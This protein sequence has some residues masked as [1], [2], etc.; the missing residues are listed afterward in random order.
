MKLN[1]NQKKLFRFIDDA[2]IDGIKK[3]AHKIIKKDFVNDDGISPFMA[4]MKQYDL[5]VCITLKNELFPVEA[6]PGSGSAILQALL[7]S[8]LRQ[9]DIAIKCGADVNKTLQLGSN[10]FPLGLAINYGNVSFA[11]KLIELGSE[12][13][14]YCKID[15]AEMSD[16]FP[17]ILLAAQTH[18][19]EMFDLIM[20]SAEK[21]STK[22]GLSIFYILMCTQERRDTD[23]FKNKVLKILLDKDIPF[24]NTS[25]HESID[26]IPMSTMFTQN[27]EPK[28]IRLREKIILRLIED[29]NINTN[30]EDL[31]QNNLLKLSV[32]MGSE[33][34]TK[35]FIKKGLSPYKQ[36]DQGYTAFHNAA[37]LKDKNTASA[38]MELLT[39]IKVDEISPL[40]QSKNVKDSHY[41]LENEDGRTA[42]DLAFMF[43]NYYAAKLL[44]QKGA[45]ITLSAWDRDEEDVPLWAQLMCHIQCQTDVENIIFFIKQGMDISSYES[46]EF[47]FT[48]SIS[49][50][51]RARMLLQNEFKIHRKFNM[52]RGYFDNNNAY[53]IIDLKPLHS[54]LKASE[55]DNSV[56]GKLSLNANMLEDIL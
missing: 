14:T 39:S 44:I 7:D 49:S 29:K 24:K 12:T 38:I 51:V 34:L 9:L 18:N 52:W 19:F 23:R 40:M 21:F 10:A 1:Q 46:A 53:E 47:N 56:L 22:N 32:R 5:D 20:D 31:H 2:D 4:A 27:M 26:P 11:K 36:D 45:R 16:E 13:D 3:I 43:N 54:I 8:D 30:Y 25:K 50:V 33:K 42:T 35:F 17:L 48:L 15:Q 28:E 41:N 55:E 6:V 37:T